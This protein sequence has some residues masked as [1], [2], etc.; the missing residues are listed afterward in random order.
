MPVVLREGPYT[1]V[2]Y[3]REGAEP[4]HVHVRRDRNEAK[5]WLRTLGVADSG[6]FKPLELRRIARILMA[7]KEQL[8]E[9]WYARHGRR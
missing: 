7:H 5:F 6:G 3:T 9:E 2:I 8:L 1:F 4:P